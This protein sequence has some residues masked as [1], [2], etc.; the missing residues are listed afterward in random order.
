MQ[1]LGD[2]ETVA[3]A[4]ASVAAQGKAKK[5]EEEKKAAPEQPKETSEEQTN[6]DKTVETVAK[7][8]KPG[9]T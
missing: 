6:K 5:A 4:I 1:F 7:Q 3:K 8:I 9:L 2:D